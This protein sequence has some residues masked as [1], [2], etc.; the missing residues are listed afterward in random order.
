MLIFGLSKYLD[1]MDYKYNAYVFNMGNNNPIGYIHANS[2]SRLRLNAIYYANK[3]N[4][5][6]GRI[7][8][9]DDKTGKIWRFNA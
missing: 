7:M 2:I 4:G 9:Q 8:V 3:Y 6:G 5:K 1:I